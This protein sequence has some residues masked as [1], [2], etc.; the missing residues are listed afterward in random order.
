MYTPRSYIYKVQEQVTLIFGYGS[1]NIVISEDWRV[2]TEKVQE[3]ASWGAGN[4]VSDGY[5]DAYIGKDSS[6]YTP[7]AILNA[8]SASLNFFTWLQTLQEKKAQASFLFQ[9]IFLSAFTSFLSLLQILEILTFFPLKLAILCST[10][11]SIYPLPC[12]ILTFQCVITWD[13]FSGSLSLD[14]IKV[15]DSAVG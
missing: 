14:I 9:V 11:L 12:A 13:K 8:Y 15:N 3:H 5:I 10:P 7:V 1:Q 2:L 6:N 4:K